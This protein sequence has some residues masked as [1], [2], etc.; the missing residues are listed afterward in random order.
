MLKEH[1]TAFL[2][3]HGIGEARCAIIVGVSGGIDSVVLLDVLDQL[4]FKPTVVHV[5][6]GLRGADSD[7]D[8]AF[9]RNLCTDR[10]YPVV[11]KRVDLQSL[12][13]ADGHS[14]QELAREVRYRE[15]DRVASS[16]GVNLIATAHH[17]EDQAET[18]L[19][20]L[21]RGAGPDGISGIPAV[22][23]I[24]RGSD[25][26][27]V[28]PLLT[29]SRASI[30]EYAQSRGLTWRDDASNQD[31]RYRRNQVRHKLLPVIV[32]DFGTAAVDGIIRSAANVADALGTG[33]QLEVDRSVIVDREQVRLPLAELEA[34]EWGY[35]GRLVL[36]IL[37]RFF[38]AT[39][40]TSDS[41]NAI[42]ELATLQTGKSWRHPTLIAARD[43]DHLVF[44]RVTPKEDV[45]ET[46]PLSLRVGR[47]IAIPGG[48][49]R[50]DVLRK[51]PKQLDPETHLI[52]FVD[53]DRLGPKLVVDTWRAGD[54]VQIRGSTSRKKVSDV[55][56]EALV[57][58]L[59]R[60]N[61]R[62]VR[63]GTAIAWIV[64]VRPGGEFAVTSQ[65]KTVIML[66]VVPTEVGIYFRS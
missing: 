10:E 31:L 21:M 53:A 27:V 46:G 32:D 35:G 8:E 18:V 51:V 42:L 15:F 23:P 4:D 55:L 11:V 43:R 49:L 7:G 6:F 62:V 58:T 19:M 28:R 37:K 34:T 3:R 12:F 5:N 22:R 33:G 36:E 64:G 52:T 65:T 24:Q 45:E 38:P 14:L 48:I 40:R 16:S 20:N 66:S 56:T 59:E 25:T 39:P 54:S 61:A 1:V 44:R 30:L 13:E 2:S 9:V 60:Q 26:K 29:C 50:A 47:P 17:R 57:P 63:N 41:V